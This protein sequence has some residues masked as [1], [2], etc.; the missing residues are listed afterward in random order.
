MRAHQSGTFIS[1]REFWADMSYGSYKAAPPPRQPEVVSRTFD[2]HFGGLTRH[3]V[4]PM[5][6]LPIAI[7]CEGCRNNQGARRPSVCET[8][9]GT[10]QGMLEAAFGAPLKVSYAPEAGGSCKLMVQAATSDDGQPLVA[11]ARRAGHVTIEAHDHGFAV[12]DTRTG[13][14]T[15]VN[16]AAWRLLNEV[17]DFQPVPALAQ[18]LELSP[19]FIEDLVKDAY[20]KTWIE[21]DFRPMPS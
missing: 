7:H 12:H 13:A 3:A 19:Q 4:Q 5:N 8:H 11:W 21:V 18:R 15:P 10:L 9:A 6:D 14:R 2:A 17:G 16:A 20:Q 1:L